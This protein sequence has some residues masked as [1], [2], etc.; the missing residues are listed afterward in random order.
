MRRLVYAP[1]AFIFIRSSNLNGKIFDVSSDVVRGSVTQNCGDVS[2]AEFE[3][4]NRYQKWLR[5]T[6]NDPATGKASNLSIFLPMDMVTIWLQR[7]AGRPIQVFTGYLDAVPYYQSY[8]GNAIFQATC[9]LKKLAFTW[10]DPGLPTF[11]QWIF[12]NGWSIDPSTGEGFNPA[13]LT[14]ATAIAGSAALSATGAQGGINDSGFANLLGRFMLD[15]AGWSADDVLIS[16][17]PKDIPKMAAQLYNKITEDTANDLTALE[18]YFSTAM[19]V[20]GWSAAPPAGTPVTAGGAPSVTAATQVIL[21]KMQKVCDASNIPILVPI[22]AA[23]LLTGMNEQY[24]VISSPAA[25]QNWGF[26]LYALRPATTGGVN[27]NSPL[28]PGA[29]GV[30]TIDGKST[31]QLLDATT[32]TQVFCDLLNQ[33]QGAWTAGA[34]KNDL[35]SIKTWVEKA[36]GYSLPNVDLTTAFNYAKQIGAISV[37]VTTPT[38]TPSTSVDPSNVTFAQIVAMPNLLSPQDKA[39][40]AKYYS[41]ASPWLAAIVVRAKNATNNRISV[42]PPGSAKNANSISLTGTNADLTSVFAT[43]TG[44]TSIASVDMQLQGQTNAKQL[45]SGNLSSGVTVSKAAS[46][47]LM[48]VTQPTKPT[49]TSTGTTSA[50]PG[51]NTNAPGSASFNQIATLSYDAAFAANF[52]FPSNTIESINLTGDRA[53]M[54]DISC[55][56]GIKQL[57]ASSLRTFRSLPDGRFLAFYP[58]YFG[59]SRK[60]YWSIYNIE[61]TDFG[62]QLNDNAL[63]THVYVVGDTFGG[64]GEITWEDEASTRGVATITQAFMLNSFIEAYSPPLNSTGT[65]TPPAI[66]RLI[67]A[68][69]F[70]AHYGAR[71]HKTEQPLIRNTLYEFLM[72]WQQFMYLW[73]QQFATNATFTFQPEVM[74][75]G[76]IS[77]PDHDV[78]MFVDSVTHEW[79]YESGFTTSAVMTAPSLTGTN[80]DRTQKPGFALGGNVNT[81]GI[82]GD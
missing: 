52:A 40:I 41:S 1:K 55:L 80:I 49:S 8:P 20:Q 81:V 27:A 13:A 28:N 39:N 71:P 45:V 7:I 74:A 47:A 14:G 35:A 5:D 65:N 50:L 4:R 56:D 53:L 51:T 23:F 43:L 6:T 36:L 24:Q 10:F 29:F 18:T 22:F 69:D 57:C 3:L 64:D 61:M 31:A 63:A 19:G 21:T 62:I 32:A 26:G 16:Q 2:S 79:D 42:A 58:D 70:L 34:R 30:A 68:Y 67:T 82:A 25:S 76:L 54:N 9:T 46:S 59:A 15:I 73:A 37:V 33:N 48:V 11:E 38:S 77:F 66:G 17:L 60:P 44:D 78:Q 75:G 72:A 12:N